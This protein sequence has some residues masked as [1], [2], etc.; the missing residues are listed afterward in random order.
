MQEHPGLK[1]RRQIIKVI[2][3]GEWRRG[4]RSVYPH[5]HAHAHTEPGLCAERGGEKGRR[6]TV[7]FLLHRFSPPHHL[8]PLLFSACVLVCVPSC[9]CCLLAVLA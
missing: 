6:E 4:C 5:T 3:G 8:R 1:E 9:S 7:S 2:Q